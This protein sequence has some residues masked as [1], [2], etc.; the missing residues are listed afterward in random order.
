MDQNLE[1]FKR[2]ELL[3]LGTM[4][5]NIQSA[6]NMPDFE[7]NWNKIDKSFASPKE[8]LS[9]NLGWVVETNKF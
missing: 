2:F 1:G 5:K 8:R 4:V 3:Q 7:A 9:H 6:G